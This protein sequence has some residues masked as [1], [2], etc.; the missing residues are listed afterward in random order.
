MTKPT[1]EQ[2]E[3]E[4][5]LY[6]KLQDMIMKKIEAGEYLPGEKL[7]SERTLAEMYGINRMTVKNAINALEAKNYLYRQQGKGTFVQKKDFHKLNLGFLNEAGNCGITAM[8]KSQGIRIANEV[9]VKGTLTGSRYISSKLT[10]PTEAEVYSLHRI[11]YGNEEPIAVEYTYVPYAL[12]PDMD[13]VDFKYVSL[14]DYM[15]SKG[16]M[17]ETFEQ[18]FQIIEVPKK[19]GKYLELEQGQ[20]VYYFEFIGLDGSGRVVEYTESYTRTDKA[21]F[22]F[23]ING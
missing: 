7:P 20:V 8:V 12:F 5:P 21:E 17:P 18:K 10:I 11:R 15:D 2:K 14:Y 4:S 6:V 22:F 3:K 13:Q 19:E 16:C 1:E 9:I 23:K